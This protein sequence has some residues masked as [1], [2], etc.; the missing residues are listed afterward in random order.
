MVLYTRNVHTVVEKF[1]DDALK[2]IVTMEN[3]GECLQK[4][5]D[6]RLEVVVAISNLEIKA[7]DNVLLDG[8]FALCIDAAPKVKAAV[9]L[10]IGPGYNKKVTELVGGLDGCTH[11][12]EMM[13]EV[14][15]CVTLTYYNNF[16]IKRLGIDEAVKALKGNAQCLG[17]DKFGQK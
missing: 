12:V 11:F 16:V 14:G 13:I 1:G 17:L 4:P 8:S 9:G 2:A 5:G 3:R 10:T 6:F 7:I 15:R